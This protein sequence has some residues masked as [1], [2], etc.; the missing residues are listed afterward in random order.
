MLRQ[1]S[2]GVPR[3]RYL[4]SPLARCMLPSTDHIENIII[5]TRILRYCL[6][7]NHNIHYNNGLPIFV[8][9]Y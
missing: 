5:E 2:V 6:A 3:D 8:M 1:A 4:C 7:T 9:Q